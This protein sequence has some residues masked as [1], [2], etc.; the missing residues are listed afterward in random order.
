MRDEM[1]DMLPVPAMEFKP[2]YDAA[3]AIVDLEFIWANAGATQALSQ[4]GGA[5]NGKR[6]W[7]FIRP[8]ARCS[9]ISHS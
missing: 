1:M 9:S 5:L 3:G 4:D 6:F 2:V 7:R 8:L